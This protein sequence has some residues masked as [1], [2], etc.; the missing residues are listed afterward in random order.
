MSIRIRRFDFDAFWNQIHYHRSIE[1]LGF[2]YK[3]RSGFVSAYFLFSPSEISDYT[4]AVSRAETYYCHDLDLDSTSWRLNYDKEELDGLSEV[5][6]RKKYIDDEIENVMFDYA[7]NPSL[8]RF[9]ID[10]LALFYDEH[11]VDIK[12]GFERWGET[13]THSRSKVVRLAHYYFSEGKDYQHP[14][15]HKL[16][17]AFVAAYAIRNWLLMYQEILTYNRHLSKG[18]EKCSSLF[19]RINAMEPEKAMAAEPF[20]I[21][22]HHHPVKPSI[23]PNLATEQLFLPIEH[24]GNYM[25]VSDSSG[26]LHF[27]KRQTISNVPKNESSKLQV[28]QKSIWLNYKRLQRFAELITSTIFPCFKKRREAKKLEQMKRDIELFDRHLNRE[29]KMTAL[30]DGADERGDFFF[31]L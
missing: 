19:N 14:Q 13:Y 29:W 6:A 15:D 5:Q 8:P 26:F 7:M 30:G 27:K 10:E 25:L 9:N 23:H 12:A 16:Y 3:H 22:S 1:C 24:D 2:D 4:E 17:K 28:S 18:N 11:S 20:V 31:I 21:T